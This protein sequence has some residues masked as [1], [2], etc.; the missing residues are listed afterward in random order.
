ML[1]ILSQIFFESESGMIESDILE[2]IYKE[3]YPKIKIKPSEHLS[4]HSVLG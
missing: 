3:M 1:E 2:R 4:V